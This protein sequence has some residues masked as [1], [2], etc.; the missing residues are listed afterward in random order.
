MI[1]KEMIDR[2]N[3]LAGKSKNEGLTEVEREEQ[4]KLRQQYIAFIKGQVKQ[5]LDCIKFVEDEEKP[6]CGCGH[7]HDDHQCCEHG[8]DEHRHDGHC[9]CGHEKH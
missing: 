3:Y 4:Q 9:K 2:I 6:G 1:T 7:S 8:Q 5:Q